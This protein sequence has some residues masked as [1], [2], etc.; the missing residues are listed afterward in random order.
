MA[1]DDQVENLQ[2]ENVASEAKDH[3]S[4]PLDYRI[5]TYPADYTLELLHQKWKA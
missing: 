4:W 2:L 3:E 5:A 1:Q